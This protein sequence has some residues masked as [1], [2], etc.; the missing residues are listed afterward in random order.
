MCIHTP[1]RVGG[2]RDSRGRGERGCP[3]RAVRRSAAVPATP[4]HK[5]FNQNTVLYCYRHS[6]RL[7]TA[8]PPCPPAS[9]AARGPS[10]SS[11]APTSRSSDYLAAAAGSTAS[12]RRSAVTQA[13]WRRRTA[14]PRADGRRRGRCPLPRAPTAPAAA[15]A[16]SLSAAGA[17]SHAASASVHASTAVDYARLHRSGLGMGAR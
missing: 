16:R 8:P 7:S 3:P 13:L 15:Y 12:R 6:A 5:V 1:G 17:P 11:Q 4:A 9:A 10:T 14:A 2:S